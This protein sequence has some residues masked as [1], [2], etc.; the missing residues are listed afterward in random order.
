MTNNY[1]TQ[2]DKHNNMLNEIA[3]NNKLLQNEPSGQLNQQLAQQLLQQQQ[4][5]QMLQNMQN[6]TGTP[7]TKP[8][9]NPQIVNPEPP[10][11]MYVQQPVMQT[12]VIQNPVMQ[13]PGMNNN[14]IQNQPNQKPDLEDEIELSEVKVDNKPENNTKPIPVP[15]QQ[16]SLP[17]PTQPPV[18]K[19]MPRPAVPVAAVKPAPVTTNG[20]SAMADYIIIPIILLV[21]FVALVHPKTSKFLEKYLPKLDSA[22]GCLIRGVILVF[23]YLIARFM[24]KGS[25]NRK[26]ENKK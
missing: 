20:S 11:M 15:P 12:P 6:F 2:L 21:T 23:V 10:K 25:G 18:T 17:R 19:N 24:T 14:N 7:I 8:Q 13:N 3:A 5:L 9:Q 16:Q 4:Q 1:H 26:I 22:K